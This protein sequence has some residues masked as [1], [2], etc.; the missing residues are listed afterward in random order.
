MGPLG[1][2]VPCPLI[3]LP[4]ARVLASFTVLL[5]QPAPDGLRL[6]LFPLFF[7]RHKLAAGGDV[8][9]FVMV[10]A[11]RTER[12]RRERVREPG[13]MEARKD[14]LPPDS[15]TV[16]SKSDWKGA[17]AAME[18]SLLTLLG[19]RVNQRLMQYAT[20]GSEVALE[21]SYFR[22][23]ASKYVVFLSRVILVE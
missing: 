23:S 7:R 1:A 11:L 14:H 10:G 18:D 8:S 12:A 21:S 6:F 9:Y 20:C 2:A 3:S 4:S 13:R 5:W 19:L 15:V 16:P 17:M 22:S